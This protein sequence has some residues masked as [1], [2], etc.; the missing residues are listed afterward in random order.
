MDVSIIIVN[1]RTPQ[2]IIDCLRSVF[3]YTHGLQIEIIVVDNDP[4]QG[5]KHLVLAEFPSVHWIDMDFNSGFGIANN[6]GMAQAKGKYLLLL[7]A[8]TLLFDPVIQRC[9][10][11]M[12]QRPDIVAAGAL[13]L[14]A[15]RSPMPYYSSFNAIRRTLF[16]VPPGISRYIDRAFPD[17]KYADPDQCDWLVGAFL[18]VRRE[19]YE[20]TK[21][22]D[23]DFFMY[24]E[25]VEWCSRLSMHGKLCYF[26][27]CQFLHLENTNPFRRTNI[28]WINRFG[29][30]MQLSNL[31]W[32]RKQYGLGAYLLMIL[33]YTSMI[34]VIYIWKIMLN[35]KNS[36][37][38]FGELRTQHLY[39][40][41][42]GVMLRYFWKT[43]LGKKFL[44]KILPSENIDLQGRL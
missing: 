33:H 42:I 29:T 40:Q 27:D 17:P 23:E 7:N 12:E 43:V 19:G 10:D 13:Q 28:S 41:K 44:F 5:G 6:R 30:Q 20:K 39:T 21:G 24:G 1:Y 34:P 14:Y 38:A 22:F 25:D 26:Q 37:K 16:I 35:I 15:D 8:D 31:L 36:G 3:K 18:F 32:I 11:R 4:I 9:Y 2:L